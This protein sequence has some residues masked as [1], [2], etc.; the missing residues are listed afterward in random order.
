MVCMHNTSTIM[1][2]L[3]EYA[4]YAYHTTLASMHTR[5]VCIQSVVLCI[6]L[7]AVVCITSH[8][9]ARSRCCQNHFQNSQFIIFVYFLLLLVLPFSLFLNVPL[10]LKEFSICVADSKST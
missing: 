3:E 9:L 2:T 10:W 7:L 4:Y 8:Q 5:V 6:I 1:H